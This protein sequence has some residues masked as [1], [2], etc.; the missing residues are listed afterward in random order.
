MDKECT[1]C[2]NKMIFNTITNTWDCSNEECRYQEEGSVDLD[3]KEEMDNNYYLYHCEECD[4]SFIGNNIYNCFIC[5]N[6]LQKEQTD[7]DYKGFIEFR[8][9]K[10]DAIHNYKRKLLIRLL[11][12]IGFRRKKNINRLKGIYLP[13]HMFD[14]KLDGN[15]VFNASD[16]NVLDVSKKDKKVDYYKV[17]CKGH[18]DYENVMINGSNK[19]KNNIIEKIDNYNYEDIK[20]MDEF[21]LENNIIYKE[22]CDEYNIFDRLKKRCNNSSVKL[23]SEVV[24]HNKKNVFKNDLDFTYTEKGIILIPMYI[25]TNKYK[26]KTYYYV[27]NGQNGNTYIDVP[28]GVVETIIFSILLLVLS[29]SI[30]LLVA[31][32]L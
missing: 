11:C 29:F 5:N 12:P 1:K 10:K 9:N 3:K 17:T 20:N 16:V 8:L 28:I 25:L 26:D 7:I 4:M 18:F 2:G 22:D 32:Y 30:M 23:M 27:M 31:L 15:V 21:N 24:E 13:M 19:F 6:S 14:T